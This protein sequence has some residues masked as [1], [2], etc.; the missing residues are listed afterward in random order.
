MCAEIGA[1]LFDK[2]QVPSVNF[3]GPPDGGIA[4]KL[5][6]GGEVPARGFWRYTAPIL[7]AQA[8]HDRAVE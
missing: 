3:T 2:T 7:V 1:I 6:A 5:P 4:Q 8:A